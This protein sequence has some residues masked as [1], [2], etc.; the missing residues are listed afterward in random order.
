MIPIRNDMKIYN[1]DSSTF[2]G[3]S[4]LNSK[5]VIQEIRSSV[6]S[7]LDL[8]FLLSVSYILVQLLSA[9]VVDFYRFISYLWWFIGFNNT[10]G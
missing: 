8:W 9:R 4:I 2:I 5:L 6:L 1:K 10:N 7:L 3:M